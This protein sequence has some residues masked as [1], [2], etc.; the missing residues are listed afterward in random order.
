VGPAVAPVGGHDDDSVVL[1]ESRRFV[2]GHL[3]LRAAAQ[4]AGDY[5][6]HVGTAGVAAMIALLAPATARAE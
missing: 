4:E 2:V 5:R 6:R 3:N 1:E